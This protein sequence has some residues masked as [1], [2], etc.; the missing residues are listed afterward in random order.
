VPKLSVIQISFRLTM[1]DAPVPPPT[2]TITGGY[3]AITP[4]LLDPWPEMDCEVYYSEQKMEMIEHFYR[5]KL[6]TPFQV[7]P[8]NM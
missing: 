2:W 6:K 5:A 8:N 3:P 1:P 4:L 7:M